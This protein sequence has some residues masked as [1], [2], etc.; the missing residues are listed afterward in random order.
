MAKKDAVRELLE[1]HGQTFCEELRIPIEKGTPSPLFRWLTACI[2]YANRIQHD[3][4]AQSARGLSKAGWRSAKA[5]AEAS[6]EDKVRVLNE[7]G[8]AQYQERTATILTDAA[9][10]VQDEYAGDL[11]KLREAS[12][13][14]VA[15]MRR[16]L[17]EIKGIGDVAVDIFLRE[18][19]TTWDEVFPFAD[20]LALKAA[21]RH[22]LGGDAKALAKLVERGDYARF[23][24][25]LVR[26]ELA[27]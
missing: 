10:L 15:A 13:G 14:D 19:Q 12:D 16:R 1:A 17:K 8:F 25:A 27:R 6:W 9:K 7:G 21:E 4:A 11:R 20:K 18:V 23:V 5:M 3:L 26:D 24:A 22:G 2:L